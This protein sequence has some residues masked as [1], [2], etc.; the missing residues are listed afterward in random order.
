M[1]VFIAVII[2]LILLLYAMKDLIWERDLSLWVQI[3][4]T[5][6]ILFT[7]ILSIFMILHKGTKEN[8][9]GEGGAYDRNKPA[10]VETDKRKQEQPKAEPAQEQSDEEVMLAIA[11]EYVLIEDNYKKS[12]PDATDSGEVASNYI[13]QKYQFTDEEW[14]NFMKHAEE[15][16]LFDKARQKIKD[17]SS[18]ID[19][20]IAK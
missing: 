3:L 20:V 10:A 8:L 12:N 15:N 13:K 1:G 19:Y 5:A 18:D 11:E 6:L 14:N 2:I 7:V 16:G 4:L 9:P 17:E